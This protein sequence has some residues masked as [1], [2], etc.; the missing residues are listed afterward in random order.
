MEKPTVKPKTEKE[1]RPTENK[2]E[3]KSTS[4]SHVEDWS[5]WKPPTISSAN[6]PFE[7]HIGLRQTKK[8]M[9]R[10]AKDQELK[11]KETIPGTYIEEEK[12]EERVI[13]PTKFQNQ[14]NL[15]WKLKI[16]PIKMRMKKF[17]KKK[18]SLEK[19]KRKKLKLNWKLTKF[20]RKLCNKRS[21]LLLKKF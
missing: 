16:F 21:T 14:T 20:L 10:Q 11:K 1:V 9:E 2:S 12:E 18:I 19:L 15:R 6:D 4:T 5:N 13:I 17:S 8:R 3:D 7:S